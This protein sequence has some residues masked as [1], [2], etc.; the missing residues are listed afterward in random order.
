[1][2]AVDE[3]SFT[4]S[5][6]VSN[7]TSTAP[8]DASGYD[9]ITHMSPNN[10]WERSK[11]PKYFILFFQCEQIKYNENRYNRDEPD[12]HATSVTYTLF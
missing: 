2:S 3:I 11:M 4:T 7:D 10:A 6:H 9:A 12:Y 8:A 1:M 5:T